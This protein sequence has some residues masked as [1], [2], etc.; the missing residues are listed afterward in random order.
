MELEIILVWA[1]IM[2][3]TS[4]IVVVILLNLK[5]KHEQEIREKDNEIQDKIIN[6]KRNNPG[7]FNRE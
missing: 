5:K 4:G 6:W 1:I 3:I 2:T 7:H